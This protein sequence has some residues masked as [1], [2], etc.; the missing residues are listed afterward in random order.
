[1][2]NQPYSPDPRISSTQEP[3]NDQTIYTPASPAPVEHDHTV[4][5][6]QDG[7]AYAQR[8]HEQYVDPDG[9]RV[10]SQ[11]EIIKDKNQERANA[12][13]WI[14]SI[15][16]FILGV[17]EV[18]LGLRLLFRL[19]AANPENGFISF[20]YNLSYPF[21]APF[22]GIFGNPGMNGSVFEVSTL[23][24]MLVYALLAWGLVSLG[25]VLFA[26]NF[27][28]SQNITTTRQRRFS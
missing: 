25:R 12:R 23:I 6:Y 24:A 9:N 8:R 13:Y 21:V 2:T 26:P 10:E 17:L 18:I 22:N 15:V 20:L 16:Y 5:A 7:N 11:Q 27:S 28:G 19:L 3:Y 1:M 4:H 14:A